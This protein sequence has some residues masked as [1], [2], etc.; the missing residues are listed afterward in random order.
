LEATCYQ[1]QEEAHDLVNQWANRTEANWESI[2][3]KLSNVRAAWDTAGCR[4]M[5]GNIE[6]PKRGPA[7][8][9]G[10]TVIPGSNTRAGIQ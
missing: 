1:L 7:L 2:R 10:T 6:M 9:T 5:Y 4:A 3:A 8:P